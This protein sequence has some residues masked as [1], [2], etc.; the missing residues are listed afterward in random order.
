MQ[1]LLQGLPVGTT[2]YN[3]TQPSTFGKVAGGSGDVMSMIKSYL[4]T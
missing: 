4:G 1:S 3:Y 2:A